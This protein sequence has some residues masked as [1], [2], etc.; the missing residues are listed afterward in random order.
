[1]L[2]DGEQTNVV[3]LIKNRYTIGVQ[4]DFFPFRK[5][6]LRFDVIRSHRRGR[7]EQQITYNANIDVIFV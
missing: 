4:Q 6:D 5:K 3:V 7:I 2:T 1:V